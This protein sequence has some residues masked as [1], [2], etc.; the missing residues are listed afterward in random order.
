MKCY[1]CL[2]PAFYKLSETSLLHGGFYKADGIFR[3]FHVRMQLVDSG[4]K[5]WAVTQARGCLQAELK[6]SAVIEQ[7]QAFTIYLLSSSINYPVF[8]SS[9]ADQWLVQNF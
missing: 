5:P 4:K 1:W 9:H 8:L 7:V 3:R 6:T 2:R